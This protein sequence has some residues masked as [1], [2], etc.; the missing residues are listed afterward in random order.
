MKKTVMTICI[1]TC[2]ALIF[3]ITVGAVALATPP[4]FDQTFLGEL[5]CKID[6]LESIDQPKII[7]VGGSSVAFGLRS[8][9]MEQ[10]LGMPVVNLGL[11]AS[12]GTKLMLDI[13]KANIG[14]DD[15][16]IIAPEQDAQTLSLYFNADSAWK[17]FDGSFEDLKYVGKDDLPSIAGGLMGFAAEKYKYLS[18]GEKP[19]VSGVY[20]KEA[21]NSYCDIDYERPSNTMFGGFDK[22]TPISFDESIISQD[23]IDYLNQYAIYARGRG[24]DVFFSFSPMNRAALDENATQEQI[25]SYFCHLQNSLDFPVISSPEAYLME[26]NWFYDSNFH[27]NDAGAILHTKHLINDIILA[28]RLDKNCTVE[29]PEMPELSQSGDSEAGNSEL[30]TFNTTDQGIEITGLTQKGTEQTEIEVPAAID[31]KT[32]V[33]ISEGAFSANTALTKITVNHGIA[34]IADGAF[35]GCTSLKE[36]VVNSS[37]PATI[38]VGE[39]LLRGADNCRIY[40]PKGA[41]GTYSTDYYWAFYCDSSSGEELA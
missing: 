41:Y 5:S 7:V 33:A 10:Q 20:T 37:E 21:F 11:Y 38:R 32:V 27:M 24:A 3:P 26:P 4:Q 15:I 35:D 29:T 17:A 18:K 8:D 22:N 2:L 28:L 6:R 31:G 12:L 25:Y 30:F 36:L 16:V 1:L 23:F 9:I 13:S 19:A 34:Y 14:K 40:V 39:E